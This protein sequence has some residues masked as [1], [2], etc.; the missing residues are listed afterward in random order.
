MKKDQNTF[1][2]LIVRNAREYSERKFLLSA[3]KVED[4]VTYSEVL[5]FVKSFK[6][7]LAQN[8]VPEGSSIAVLLPNDI[9]TALLFL[10]IPATG[11]VFIP[12]NPKLTAQEVEYI[13]SDSSV[14]FAI[15]LESLRGRLPPGLKIKAV[16]L[17]REWIDRILRDYDNDAVELQEIG[18]TSI[19]EIVYTSG[20]TGNPKGVELSH[21]NLMANGRGIFEAFEFTGQDRFLTI[22]PLFHNS[23]QLFTTLAPMWSGS[24]SIPVRPEVALG[25]FWGLIEEHEVTWTL[26]MGSHINFLLDQS[27]KHRKSQSTL[28]GILTGGMKL[29]E[30]KRR[31]FEDSF[32]TEIFITYGLTETTSFATCERFG[33]KGAPGSVGKPMPVNEI[34]VDSKEP[35]IEGEILIRGENVFERY[36][37]LPEL[38]VQ[39]KVNGWLR[40]GDIGRFDAFGNLFITDRIDNLVIVSGENVYPAEIEKH[41]HLLSEI[42]EYIVVG[43][44][45]A[46]KGVELTMVYTLKRGEV[47]NPSN[48]KKTLS[49]VLTNYKVPS[50]YLNVTDLGFSELPKAANGKILRG[51]IK[52][53]LA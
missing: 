21:Q 34:M 52:E 26:G 3:Y 47:D 10:T 37:N 24:T 25:A 16:S 50:R 46:I 41:S 33:E 36:H 12:L 30:T 32:G 6:L 1:V 40:T 51:K 35:G 48:W 7:F 23:G 19:A 17:G 39:R 18:E 9:L 44:P 31:D 5:E 15:T 53:R 49:S 20:T 43:T 38:T 13:C 11:C 8:S 27:R 42:F 28:K 45:H 4:G 2:E 22:T 29:D 14:V